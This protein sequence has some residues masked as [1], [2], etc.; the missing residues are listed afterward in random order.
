MDGKMKQ[1][2][3]DTANSWYLRAS[4]SAISIPIL[5]TLKKNS[6]SKVE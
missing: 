3:E 6:E 5:L 4:P 2:W 1:L